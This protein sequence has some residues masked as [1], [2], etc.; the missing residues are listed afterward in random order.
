M[1]SLHFNRRQNVV[2]EMVD[3]SLITILTRIKLRSQ[4]IFAGISYKTC[5]LIDGLQKLIPLDQQ[6]ADKR[7]GM[8]LVCHTHLTSR[9]TYGKF[10]CCCPVEAHVL[11]REDRPVTHITIPQI[12]KETDM[13]RRKLRHNF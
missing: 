12:S 2:F 10:L 8:V 13:S 7:N 5:H 4:N 3:L 6:S 9:T 1:A 11:N